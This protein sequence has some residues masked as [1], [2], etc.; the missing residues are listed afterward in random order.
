M[1]LFGRASVPFLP[2]VPRI[3]NERKYWI[4]FLFQFVAW[5]VYV[6]LPLLILLQIQFV[7]LPYQSPILTPVHFLV[8]LVDVLLI[9]LLWKSGNPYEWTGNLA[10]FLTYTINTAS[11]SFLVL[12]MILSFCLWLDQ[13]PSALSMITDRLPASYLNYNW[14]SLS[15][16]GAVLMAREPPASIVVQ[17]RNEA[18]HSGRPI[19]EGETSAYLDLSAAEPLD[20]SHRSLRRAKLQDVKLYGVNLEGADLRGASLR[21]ST[22]AGARLHDAQLAGAILVFAQF[23]FATACINRNSEEQ[24][25]HADFTG[26]DLTQALLQG[27]DFRGADFAA[28]V[29]D[30]AKLQAA[31]LEEAN[32]EGANLQ[33][34]QLRGAALCGIQMQGADLSST[35]LVATQFGGPPSDCPANQPASIFG[36]SFSD[37]TDVRYADFNGLGDAKVGPERLAELYAL[38]RSG[39]IG[40]KAK[41]RLARVFWLSD[42]PPRAIPTTKPLPNSQTKYIWWDSTLPDSILAFLGKS[43]GQYPDRKSIYENALAG[44]LAVLYCDDKDAATARGLIRRLWSSSRDSDNYKARDHVILFAHKVVSMQSGLDTPTPPCSR[45]PLE[46][47]ETN[48]MLEKARQ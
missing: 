29:L 17:L 19:A 7:F 11:R 28:A 43:R 20:L 48:F 45:P 47:Y 6:V 37:A 2:L 36:V 25:C 44:E 15:I 14:S 8:L 34:A 4:I 10:G 9:L 35:N 24:H 27:A 46:W 23:K 40:S 13:R 1:S 32:F 3:D 38:A 39:D 21:N 30:G 33:G 41:E 26:A 16:S 18:I 31:N 12:V 42:S 22:L 5:F